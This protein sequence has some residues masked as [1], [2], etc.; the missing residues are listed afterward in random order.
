MSNMN[1][2]LVFL[3]EGFDCLLYTS[4]KAIAT[5]LGEEYLVRN[6]PEQQPHL[7]RLVA[8]E[9][10]ITSVSYTHLD[11]YKRQLLSYRQPHNMHAMQSS[12]GLCP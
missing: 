8:I 3:A 5:K 2:I 12:Q 6:R 9:K 1:N 11:V 7:M 4:Q 10:W